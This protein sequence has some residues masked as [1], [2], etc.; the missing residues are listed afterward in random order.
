MQWPHRTG[1][2]FPFLLSVFLFLSTEY[3]LKSCG[4]W[5]VIAGRALLHFFIKVYLPGK[6]KSFKDHDFINIYSA[7]QA[8][9]QFWRRMGS[10]SFIYDVTLG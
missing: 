9:L 7:K 3:P 4:D 10:F 6:I 1:R 5:S 2:S 8:S